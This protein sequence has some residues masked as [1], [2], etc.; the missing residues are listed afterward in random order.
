MSS[1]SCINSLSTTAAF[2]SSEMSS[3]KLEFTISYRCI[4]SR[5]I[6]ACACLVRNHIITPTKA[7]PMIIRSG[8]TIV[9]ECG[10]G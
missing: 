1:C 7:S 2:A 5:S 4:N 9:F 8:L 10:R 6:A 3:T